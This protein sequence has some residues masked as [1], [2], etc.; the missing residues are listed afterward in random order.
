[1]R[2]LIS[3]R[4][5]FIALPVVALAL[6]ALVASALNI[7]QLRRIEPFASW[8]YTNK[9][10]IDCTWKLTELPGPDVCA[11]EDVAW[12]KSLNK[13][14]L[15]PRFDVTPKECKEWLAKFGRFYYVEFKPDEMIEFGT[16][17]QQTQKDP[18]PVL[19]GRYWLGPSDGVELSYLPVGGSKVQ[20]HVKIRIEGDELT[21]THESGSIA[22]FTRVK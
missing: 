3:S 13:N 22:K 12:M 9:G 10:K 4:Y 6:A 21:M 7:D 16:G 2:K 1:M 11:W 14:T 19:K 18:N 8:A 20:A 5:R 15:V 17:Y